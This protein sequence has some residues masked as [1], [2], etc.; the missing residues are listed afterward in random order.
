MGTSSN[1]SL[2]GNFEIV[3]TTIIALL[4]FKKNV[5]AKLWLAII[6]I[7]ISSIILSFEGKG[8]L[9]FSYGSLVVILATI[10]W[11]F[12]NNCTRKISSKST[13]Q[14]VT[15]KGIFSGLG[16]LIIALVIG[17]PLGNLKF[18]GLT[19]VLGFVAYGLSIFLYIK[20]QSVLGA[21][22]TSAYYALAPFIGSFLSFLINGETLSKS[23]FIGLAFMVAG[24]VFVVIDTCFI[25]HSH[26]HNHIITHTHDGYEHTHSFNHDHGH[27]HFLST[28]KP[29][30]N[31]FLSEE[32]HKRLHQGLRAK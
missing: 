27:K 8:A 11:G 12:E 20:S 5:S 3:A 31:E 14:I 24:S 4:I 9:K 16:S 32:E 2:L 19:M 18:I 6:L 22:K 21:V 30:H 28:D 15:I 23:Y 17:E 26:V 13:Y 1:A 10:S 25:R 29:S 7:S